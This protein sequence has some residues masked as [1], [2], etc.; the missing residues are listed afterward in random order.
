MREA[1]DQELKLHALARAAAARAYAGYSGFSVGAA[2]ACE[3]ADPVLGVNVENRSY[4]LTCCA[5]RTAFFA[6]VT[7]GH[8]RFP[9]I[10]VHADADTVVPCGACLQVMSELAPDVTVI[11]PSGGRIVATPLSE[12]LPVQFQM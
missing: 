10:A 12:L 6:A 5:E 3:G 1:T 2:V 8:R 9:A 4:G 7:A 11:H